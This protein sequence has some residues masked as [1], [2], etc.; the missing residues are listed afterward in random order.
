MQHFGSLL[1]C[2]FFKWFLELHFYL[3]LFNLLLLLFSLLRYLRKLP[4]T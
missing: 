1:I 2:S 4:E 3:Y